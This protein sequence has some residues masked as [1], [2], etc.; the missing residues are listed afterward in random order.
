MRA[1]NIF[2]AQVFLMYYFHGSPVS[3]SVHGSSLVIF[4]NELLHGGAYVEA[5]AKVRLNDN[6]GI[7][8]Q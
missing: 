5:W 6:I 2:H 4:W 3:T 1:S 7:N 8:R